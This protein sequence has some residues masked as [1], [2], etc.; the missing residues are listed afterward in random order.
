MTDIFKAAVVANIND[1]LIGMVQHLD[2][3]INPALVQVFHKG[4][5]S[6]HFEHITEIGF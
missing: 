1:P 2:R 5:M 4:L 3:G 6:G